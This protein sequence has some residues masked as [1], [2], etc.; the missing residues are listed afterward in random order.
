MLEVWKVP[1]TVLLIKD[2]RACQRCQRCETL[3]CNTNKGSKGYVCQRCQ[4][5]CLWPL[6]NT[7]YRVLLLMSEVSKVIVLCIQWPLTPARRE[8]YLF[9]W[10]FHLGGLVVHHQ[11]VWGGSF[12]NFLGLVK[13]QGWLQARRTANPQFLKLKGTQQPSNSYI[14]MGTKLHPPYPKQTACLV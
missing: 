13:L 7:A 5:W 6:H 2:Q 9:I 10:A 1:N 3:Y 4:K 14:S 11:S 12:V 8:G